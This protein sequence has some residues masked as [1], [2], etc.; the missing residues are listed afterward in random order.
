MLSKRLF[1]HSATI[2][3]KFLDFFK[4]KGHEIVPSSSVVPKNDPTLL[5]TAAGMVQFKDLFTG[6]ATRQ[7]KRAVSIQKCIRI[8]GKHNDL[9]N[10]GETARHQ[11][12]FEML[13]NFSF[14]DY[15]KQ[16][17]CVFAWEFLTEILKMDTSKLFVTVF[18]GNEDLKPDIETENIWKKIGIP[19]NRIIRK[20]FEDN[21]WSIG[22][23]GPCG[24]CTEIHYERSFG[25]TEEDRMLEFWNL[26]FIQYERKQNGVLVPLAI[27]SVDTGMG[28]ERLC[29]ILNN[30]ESNYETDL[31]RNIINQCVLRFKIPY[32]NSNSGSDIAMRILADHIRT[33]SFMIAD[34]VSPNNDGRGYVL[35]RM[36]RRSVHYSEKLGSTKPFLHEL[37]RTVIEQ[38]KTIYPEL[39]TAGILIEKTIIQEEENFR[40]TL[41]H[42]LGLLKKSIK[43]LKNNNSILDGSIV[44]KLFETYGFPVDLTTNIA[45]EN[46]LEINWETF[47]IAKIKHEL[48]SGKNLGLVGIADIYKNLAKKLG[49]TNFENNQKMFVEIIGINKDELFL[50]KTPF[51]AESGGQ[52][53]DTGLLKGLNFEAKVI[54]T[55]KIAGLHVHKIVTLSGEISIGTKL[56]AIVD[57]ERRKDI[58]RNHSATHLLHSALRQKFGEHVVQRGSFVTQDHLRFDFSHFSPITSK[59]LLEIEIKINNWILSNQKT[60]IE[61]ISSISAK[62]RGAIALFG[63]K[64]GEK[65]RIVKIGQYSLEL[66][67]GSHVSRT[68][69]I[70]LFKIINESTVASG[71]HRIEAITGKFAVLN[72]Q[73]INTLLCEISSKL[74]TKPSN[75]QQ[76]LLLMQ[77][78]LIE[79]RKQLT[80]FK[81]KELS[82]IISLLIAEAKFIKGIKIIVKKIENVNLELLKK[83][84]DEIKNRLQSGIVVL[85]I[86][87]QNTC[88][89]TVSV[90][91]DLTNN[92][93]A[94]KIVTKLAEILEGKG[95]GGADFAQA[96][97]KFPHLLDKALSQIEKFL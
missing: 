70:G 84:A 21:F 12:F 44:F 48:C 88:N 89:V 40:K 31:L 4:S 8:G 63:E 30:L 59:E 13:G 57:W 96:G 5:F 93:H 47:K 95:G 73:K 49:T 42:G 1:M 41:F 45:Q 39:H 85:G 56:E 61:E 15:F 23:T 37:S 55:K 81:N 68:G 33:I 67:T 82:K 72:M 94:G 11:T 74:N 32:S 90:T 46:G 71:I 34:G 86:Q 54:D 18:G 17:A 78:E 80:Q 22:D 92:F 25:N 16:E 69:D 60:E 79:A 20:G 3:K 65:V 64:Y 24:P 10:V 87:T 6:H 66:C 38:Y 26:V 27:P 19:S 43:N 14:G 35:R 36:I 28:L 76:E 62:E 91:K 53:G 75:L 58:E 2:R 97:G 52:I 51:Y 50:D 9:E 29:M 83:Y 77:N 7:Y